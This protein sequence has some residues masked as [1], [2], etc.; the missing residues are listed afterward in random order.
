V[1]AHIR[2]YRRSMLPRLNGDIHGDLFVTGNG[3]RKCQDT[4]TDQIID[5][6]ES[7]VGVHMTPHQFRHFAAKL[8]LDKHP[9][10]F[11][12]VTDLL[13]HASAKTTQIYAGVS[14]QRASRAYS[15]I[16]C[17]QRET[18]KLKRP[19]RRKK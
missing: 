13:G 6:I 8:N 2:W 19:R 17:D 5:R 9:E 1:A 14:S 10:D 16:I 11:R 12:T 4:F 7:H 15:K 18:L 3:I